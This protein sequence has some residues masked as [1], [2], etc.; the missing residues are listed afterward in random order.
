MAENAL[1]E[2]NDQIVHG[3]MSIFNFKNSNIIYNPHV[4]I[5][6]L[7]KTIFYPFVGRELYIK[8]YNNKV[9][10]VTISVMK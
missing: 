7:K 5:A 6:V 10:Y 1:A 3:I 2:K 8:F 9:R 4:F